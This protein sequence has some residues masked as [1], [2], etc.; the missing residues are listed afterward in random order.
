MNPFLNTG[1]VRLE[2]W[3]K[4]REDIKNTKNYK[5]KIALVNQW[6]AQA[7]LKKFVLDP[8]DCK[9]W[10]TPWEL[11]YEGNFCEISRAYMIHQTLILSNN[12]S[13]YFSPERFELS[14]I[15]DRINEKQTMILTWHC[16]HGLD[17]MYVFNYEYNVVHH[18]T[19]MPKNIE[20]IISYIHDGEK[21][22]EV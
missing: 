5:D 10:L 20:K 6:W 1:K 4:L 21:Y 14:Y 8:L 12:E 19:E 22:I 13:N 9:K 15:Q 3:K 16:K 11:L 7:P 2:L 17:N 18:I